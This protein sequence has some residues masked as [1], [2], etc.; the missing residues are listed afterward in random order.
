MLNILE[1]KQPLS[2]R[3]VLVPV[4]FSA[5]SRSAL[6]HAAL[7]VEGTR[8]PLLVLHVVHDLPGNP[9]V[10]RKPDEIHPSRPMI[11]IA[12]EMLGEMLNELRGEHPD[13]QAL[14]NARTRLI[15]GVPGK[16]IIELAAH[17]QATMIVMGTQG[18]KGLA[19]LLH[20]SVAEYVSKHACVPVTT[21]RESEPAED[22]DGPEYLAGQAIL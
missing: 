8:T 11:D 2:R 7:M 22:P 5:C 12:E 20:G 6:V 4:D 1:A 9:G 18:R 13:L 16:R 15:Q 21:V 19:H 10:Y 17:E 3:P 14:Q